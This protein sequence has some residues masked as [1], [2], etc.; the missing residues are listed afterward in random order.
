MKLVAGEL[1]IITSQAISKSEKKGRLRLLKKITYYA[2]NFEI[3]T[4]RS[5]YSAVLHRTRIGPYGQE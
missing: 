5:M 4:V 3:A 1:E 2:E